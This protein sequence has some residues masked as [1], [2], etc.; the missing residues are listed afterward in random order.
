[1]DSLSQSV[2]LLMAVGSPAVDDTARRRVVV[3]LPTGHGNVIDR[4][5]QVK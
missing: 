1:M 5:M 3:D 2:G 4:M